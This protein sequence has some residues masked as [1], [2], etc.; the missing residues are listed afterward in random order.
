VRTPS[1]IGVA[2]GVA[3]ELCIVVLAMELIIF[4]KKVENLQAAKIGSHLSTITTL[5]TTFLP[6]KNHVLHTAF[7]KTPLKNKGKSREFT[8]NT[9]PKKIPKMTNLF[10]LR[11]F[12]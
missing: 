6:S 12:Q 9:G 7:A 2:S 8:L 5:R 3:W 1:E 10:I 11:C 4:F